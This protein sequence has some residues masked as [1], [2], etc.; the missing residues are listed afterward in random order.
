[1]QMNMLEGFGTMTEFKKVFVDTAP[2]IYYL[3]RNEQYFEK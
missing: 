3:E 1:M 2:L